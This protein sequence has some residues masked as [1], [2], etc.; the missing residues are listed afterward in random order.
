M[1]IG[2]RERDKSFII[3]AAPV[4]AILEKKEVSHF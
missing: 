3:T 2:R 1:N 4:E